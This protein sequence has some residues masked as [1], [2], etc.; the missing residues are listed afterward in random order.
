MYK[1]AITLAFPFYAIL[2]GLQCYLGYINW[3]AFIICLTMLFMGAAIMAVV[4][5]RDKV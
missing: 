1:R 2:L 4:A 5:G 3:E